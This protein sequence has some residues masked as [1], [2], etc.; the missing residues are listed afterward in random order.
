M[1][2]LF[3]KFMLLISDIA[4]IFIAFFIAFLVRF[5]FNIPNY[6]FNTTG[7]LLFLAT[8]SYILIFYLFGLY[9]SL[10]RYMSI[11]ELAKLVFASMLGGIASYF[12]NITLNNPAPR[13]VLL[14]TW[15]LVVFAAGTLR[16]GY[17]VLRRLFRQ[18]Q[19]NPQNYKRVLIIGAGDAAA[20]LIKELNQ[21]STS[22]LP[23]IAVDDAKWKEKSKI[24]GVPILNGINNIRK[25][26]EEH[27]IDEIFIAIPTLTRERF[28]E[29]IQLAQETKCRIKTLPSLYDIVNG[30]VNV[31]SIRD[32]NIEDLLGR[33]EVYLDIKGITTYLEN[34]VVIV[35]GGGGSIGSEL[36]RQIC[37]FKPSHL[38]I[39]DNY[40]N[41]A[42]DLE[43]EL[44]YKYPQ[45]K[46]S[47]IIA[48]VRDNDRLERIFSEFQPSVIF[49]AAAH[50]HVP[51]METNP[52]EAVK[53]NV[54]GTYNVAQCAHKHKAKR[55]VLISTD[56]AVNPTN[57]MGA[58]KRIA[59]MIIQSI[60]SQ[61]A[62]EFSA[63]RFGN[64]LGSNGSVIPTFKKQISQ[65]GPV[66]VTHPDITRYFM[67]IPEAA[68]LVLQAGAIAEGGEIFVLDMGEPVKIIDLAKQLIKLSGYEPNVDIKIEITGLRPGEKLYEELL[69][70][71]EGIIASS[72]EEIYTAKPVSIDSEN[73]LEQI[74]KYDSTN[75]REWISQ[76]VTIHKQVS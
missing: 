33:D 47:I 61:S 34:E 1:Q 17:R 70:A 73:L 19:N 26:S 75:T 64:V 55:F 2:V 49:H 41:N 18:S 56:K 9:N 36:C 72:H 65:G 76:F 74:M 12:L 7:P 32:V 23:I 52:E 11:D 13:S 59:E 50:K 46:V 63:V 69:L 8:L 57:V 54:L 21:S 44:H 5:E 15:I 71:E 28:K 16:L 37:K 68:R 58:T 30:Q 22:Y 40:E 25:Y 67:T 51:L 31:Q 66:T 24:L 3:R 43:Q 29:V 42:F 60:N 53:N 38:L 10:W 6:Y 27:S 14:I 35:T 39:L 48:N 4:F 45:Q 62:T 20:M